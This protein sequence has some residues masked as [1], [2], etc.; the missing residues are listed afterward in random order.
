MPEQMVRGS[1]GRRRSPPGAAPAPSP[2][3]GAATGTRHSMV[4]RVV[5]R[6][7]TA[8]PNGVSVVSRRRFISGVRRSGT[9]QLSASDRTWSPQ[10]SSDLPVS[11]A[12]LGPGIQ[13]PA[14]LLR[15]GLVRPPRCRFAASRG[16]GAM[17]CSAHH[18]SR[19]AVAERLASSRAFKP[20]HHRQGLDAARDRCRAR[21]APAGSA[22]DSAR[23][24][25][26]RED[27]ATATMAAPHQNSIPACA[28]TPAAKW[29]FTLPISVTRSAASIRAGLAL[30]P[31]TMTWRSGRRARK[32]AT[33]A[34]S[35][36]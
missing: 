36:R 27:S 13:A 6:A 32:A 10:A 11:Q 24:R 18:P 22:P 28:F 8:R 7:W 17:P 26:S 23:Q 15:G 3:A 5:P 1:R 12:R 21:T 16:V 30:R 25:P 4:C 34:S 2:S 29:C 31:V 19:V 33:T 20:L 14:R 9:Y 35:G